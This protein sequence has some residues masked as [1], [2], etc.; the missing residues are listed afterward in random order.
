MAQSFSQMSTLRLQ[1][2][3]NAII[4]LLRKDHPEEVAELVL[5]QGIVASRDSLDPAKTYA[6][7]RTPSTAVT[8]LL[9]EF[10]RPMKK[11]D[12]Y[13]E[14]RGRGYPIDTSAKKQH[15]AD[16][17]NGMLKRGELVKISGERGEMIVALANQQVDK[18]K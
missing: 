5:L 6:L 15:V 9:T 3:I 11:N 7:V 1:N 16:S 4:D 2:R 13:T 14:L 8:M 18:K 10:G 12:I 17:M